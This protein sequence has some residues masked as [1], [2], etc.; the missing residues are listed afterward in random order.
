MPIPVVCPGCKSRFTVSDRF[1][2]QT[3]PCPK[4]K[5]PITIPANT[6]KAVTIHEPE[7]AAATS[8]GGRAPLAPIRRIDQPISTVAFVA[9]VAGALTVMCLAW[10]S[11]AVFP[12]V[13]PAWLAAT[14]GFLVA[15]P[16]AALGYVGV[17]DR[18]LEPYHGRDF[19]LR[20]LACA[21][22]Y[23]GLWCARGLLPPERTAEMWNWLY[24]GPL[25]F[26]PG[27]IAAMAAFDL[28]QGRA[29]A[30]FSLYAMFTALLRWLAG[31]TP[32]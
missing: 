30:H 28:D 3:G 8:A 5:K 4:C 20:S 31:L 1:A 21:A 22:I 9:T 2:G 26:I 7:P 15:V 14:V 10:L 6:V 11:R 23:A 19:L 25:F 29:I 32:L 13:P 12:P 17:R 16:C 27:V 18:E 24:L